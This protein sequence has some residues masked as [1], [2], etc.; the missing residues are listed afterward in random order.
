MQ[1]ELFN[2]LMEGYEGQVTYI[3]KYVVADT[4]MK[5]PHSPMEVLAPDGTPV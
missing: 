4:Q 5:S 3:H 1:P 2:I